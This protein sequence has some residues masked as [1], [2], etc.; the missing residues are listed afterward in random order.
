MAKLYI[1]DQEVTP[2]IIKEVAKPDV[3]FGLSI[4]NFIGN[5]DSD[6]ALDSPFLS[7]DIV[8]TGVKSLKSSALY[9]VLAYTKYTTLT[10]VIFS[11][12]DL[13]MIAGYSM[14]Y[15]LAENNGIVVVD[16][17]KI[18]ECPNHAMSNMCY[19]CGNLS[20]IN[21]PML[22]IVEGWG[23]ENCCSNCQK[24]TTVV[25]SSLRSVGT[26]GLFKCFTGCITL[27]HLDLS[28]LETIGDYG[29]QGMCSLCYALETIDL[30][31]LKSIGPNALDSFL[32][33][34]GSQPGVMK[35]ID[36]P[37]LISVEKNSLGTAA[38]SYAFRY[39]TTLEEIHFR[40]D[41]RDTI[42]AMTGYANKWGA[43]NATIY[44]DL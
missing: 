39:R 5:V 22:E 18:K 13:I 30:S 33:G 31:K 1:G 12:P 11:A 42:E 41:M 32:Q 27:Q 9:G 29:C 4:G 35:R 3:R 28:S 44:F 16:I 37:S 38:G 21:L 2:A 8:L 20:N 23:L 40:A 36:F 14:C 7:K 43:T 26:Y 25:V 6:G 15:A 34:T 19:G 17:P 10:P 24:L